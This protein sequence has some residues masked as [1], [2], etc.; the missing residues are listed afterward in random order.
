MKPRIQFQGNCWTARHWTFDDS[1]LPLLL[2]G[3]GATPVAAF[4]SLQKVR[5]AHEKIIPDP[6]RL[7]RV[8]REFEGGRDGAQLQSPRGDDDPPASADSERA[9]GEAVTPLDT[10]KAWLRSRG[11]TDIKSLR[12]GK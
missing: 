2:Q 5:D 11:I 3:V 9:R 6:T 8:S 7:E 1:S 10:A 12:S 4:E